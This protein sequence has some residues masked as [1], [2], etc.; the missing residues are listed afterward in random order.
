[1]IAS[2]E[3]ARRARGACPRNGR[4]SGLTFAP[5][6]GSERL[7]KVINKMVTEQDLINTVTDYAEGL[8][9]L[10]GKHAR[11]VVDDDDDAAPQLRHGDGEVR[12][13]G[14]LTDATLAARDGEHGADARDRLPAARGPRRPRHT[15]ATSSSRENTRP[16]FRAKWAIR[17]NTFGSTLRGCPPRRSSKRSTS[18]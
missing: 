16:G 15:D 5:E 14:G 18:S 12:R 17:S 6:G 8:D 10:V 4:R 7:R 13:D 11:A 9:D 3:G 2:R 1:M